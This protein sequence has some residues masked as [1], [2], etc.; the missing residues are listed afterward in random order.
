M[1]DSSESD[2]EINQTGGGGKSDY[3][4]LNVTSEA[5]ATVPTNNQKANS[6]GGAEDSTAPTLA[7][8]DNSSICQEEEPEEEAEMNDDLLDF[9]FMDDDELLNEALDDNWI[10][11]D[12]L[13]FGG[14]SGKRVANFNGNFGG[15]SIHPPR[16]LHRIEEENS[17]K[18][19]SSESESAGEASRQKQ[20]EAIGTAEEAQAPD[21]SNSSNK[22]VGQIRE[23]GEFTELH[24]KFRY[25]REMSSVES[26]DKLR[27]KQ[28]EIDRLLVGEG[29]EI[30]AEAEQPAID[31]KLE[32]ESCGADVG[33]KEVEQDDF[34]EV[35]YEL[36]EEEEEKSV[37]SDVIIGII[38]V[39]LALCF[40]KI[41]Q[42]FAIIYSTSQNKVIHFSNQ[43]QNNI[44]KI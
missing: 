18:S 2:C 26:S 40:P 4:N 19:T 39:V 22:L 17:Q 21:S 8:V 23:V 38:R 37:I 12:D 1:S 27:S 43:N 41:S 33:V 13:I 30:G 25:E 44:L 3:D 36:V 24:V 32:Y 15:V 16:I 28:C 14:V 5:A 34:I 20:L 7:D 42:A 11:E 10:Q 29:H 6:L 35:G 9:N 31:I